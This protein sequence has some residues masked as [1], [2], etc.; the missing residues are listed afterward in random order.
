MKTVLIT[1]ANGQDGTNLII[2]LCENI[3]NIKLFCS[4][5]DLSTI[6]STLKEY[7]D[8]YRIFLVKLDL[9]NDQEIKNVFNNILPDYFIN[10]GGQSSVGK[11]WD[12]LEYTFKINT[13][14]IV[15][16]L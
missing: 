10:L 7:I 5:K 2:F 13:Y 1:G 3:S 6:N 11:S 12:N 8:K 9:S 16:I 4:V 14:S 15:T